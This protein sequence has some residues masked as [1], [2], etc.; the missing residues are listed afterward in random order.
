MINTIIK[1]FGRKIINICT[2]SPIIKRTKW[3]MNLFADYNHQIF[4]GNIWYRE[5]EERNYDLVNLGSSSGK[6]AF[7]YSNSGIK[8]MNWAVQPQTLIEDYNI[9]RHYHSILRKKGYVLITIMPFTGINKA[10]GIYDA[11]KYV[12]LDYQGEAIQPHLYKKAVRYAKF[13]ILFGKPAIL[14]LIKYLLHKESS[15]DKSSLWRVDHNPMN[16]EQLDAD[17]KKWIELWKKQFSISDLE[18]YLS[19]D[20]IQGRK[21][22]ITLMR[23]MIDFCLEREYIPVWI[24]PPVT[25]HLS[26]HLSEKFQENYIYSF[27]RE[28]NRDVKLLDYS[29]D[30]TFTHNDD[31]YFNSFFLNQ[32]GA[33]MFTNKVLN[34]LNLI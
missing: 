29:K 14:S 31:L 24:I 17:G 5:H 1:K 18:T 6:W 33:K 8:A 2:L 10:T 32:K 4:P 3:Y 20:N 15:T 25:I 21:Y 9:L 11:I 12:N 16:I 27:L 7:D 22:R 28:V 23:E 34:D 13:P 19:P 26:Q 30:T